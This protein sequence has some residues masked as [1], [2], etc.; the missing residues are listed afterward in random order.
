MKTC[1]CTGFV[2]RGDCRRVGC[3]AESQRCEHGI[4][5][6]GASRSRASAAVQLGPSAASPGS[7]Q[8][9]TPGT[10]PRC[11][12]GRGPH[13][14]PGTGNR[15]GRPGPAP[16]LRSLQSAIR[17]HSRW[18]L[19]LPPSSSVKQRERPTSLEARPS[20]DQRQEPPP[21]CE[22]PPSRLSLLL[23]LVSADAGGRVP[24]P[25]LGQP[26]W[27]DGG[28]GPRQGQPGSG[29]VGQSKPWLPAPA[30]DRR[31][32]G[33]PASCPHVASALFTW[34]GCVPARSPRPF[35]FI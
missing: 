4:S 21:T 14:A 16:E 18:P 8:P 24:S 19:R 3:A 32:K 6:L 7:D 25:P 17:G 13:P 35:R 23:C 29:R 26:R 10:A 15:G 2:L 9:C 12:T 30:A 27:K 31:G 33:D 20:P 28:P 22:H 5:R 34:R 11:R 1:I